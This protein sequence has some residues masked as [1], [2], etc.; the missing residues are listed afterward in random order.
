M[1]TTTVGFTGPSATFRR[2][3]SKPSISSSKEHLPQ[4]QRSTNQV[5]EKS[6]AVEVSQLRTLARIQLERTARMGPSL[7]SGLAVLAIGRLPQPDAP[8][9]HA[10]P[11]RYLHWHVARLQQRDRTMTPPLQLLSTPLRSHPLTFQRKE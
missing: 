6:G 9:I 11:P 5:S 7:D 10:Q 4:G 8:A 2:R 3:C 1:G